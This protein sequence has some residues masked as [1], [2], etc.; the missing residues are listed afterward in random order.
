MAGQG[1]RGDPI[2]PAGLDIKPEPC[3]KCPRPDRASDPD[4]WDC[5]DELLDAENYA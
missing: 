5:G 3:R 2:H 1:A 4:P